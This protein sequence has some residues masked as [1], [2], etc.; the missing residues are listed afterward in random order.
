[1]SKNIIKSLYISYNAV[2]EPIVESQVIPYLKGLSRRGIKFYL[3]TFEKKR[4]GKNEKSRIRCI[5][6]KQFAGGI[7][8][9]WFYL[10]YHK[11]PTVPATI[12]DIAIGIIYSI[13]I[14]MRHK[15]DIIHARAIV[16][17]LIGY[18]AARLLSKKFI[19][20]TRGIDS[21]EYVDAG[22]WKRGGLTHKIV[23][24]LE[25]ALIKSSDYVT[26]L[27]EKF[28]EILKKKHQNKRI[29]FSVVPCA[30]D[31]EAFKPKDENMLARKLGIQDKTVLGY[32]GSLGTWYML[33]EMIDFFKCAVKLDKDIHFLILTQ[34][35]KEYAIRLIRKKG[36]DTT[37]VTVDTVTYDSMPIYLSLCKAGIF[38]IKPVFSKISSSPVKF[39]EY[40]A[41]G[42]PVV[43]NRGV[44]DTEEIVRQN[45]VGII[46]ENF[47]EPSYNKAFNDLTKLLEDKHLPE[48][49]GLT[50]EKYLSLK[51][52]IDKY[53]NIYKTLSHKT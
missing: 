25:N 2:T 15:I 33:P 12:F 26:V 27:T 41:S 23:G 40:L 4:T 10:N 5:L 19:F 42:L 28:L 3:L 37:H 52:A 20:D 31:T 8:P 46:V 29:K 49:C 6:D 14:T 21:E 16:S 38:F 51:R 32:I 11:R 48:R 17:A 7:K 18:P 22:L 45:R 13:Y 34:T 30:V 39:G 35:D 53:E 43:I 47:D 9:E 1:M 50:A 24:F 44:G 36:L